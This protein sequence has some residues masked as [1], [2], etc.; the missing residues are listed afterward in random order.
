MNQTLQIYEPKIPGLFND[1]DSGLSLCSN[2]IRL[3]QS[4]VRLDADDSDERIQ[5]LVDDDEDD[6]NEAQKRK[7]K[8]LSRIASRKAE[9]EKH[10]TTDELR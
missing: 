7:E 4:Q 10:R 1:I 6:L 8:A 9:N 3:F 2:D 5:L